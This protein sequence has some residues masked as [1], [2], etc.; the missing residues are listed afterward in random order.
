M[1]PSSLLPA[2]AGPGPGYVESWARSAGLLPL[3][4]VDEAGRGCLAG[5]VV[6]AA[7][8]IPD[9]LQIPGLND[10]KLLRAA[11]RERLEVEIRAG[12]RAI[13][14]GWAGPEVIDRINILQATFGAMRAAVEEAAGAHGGPIGIIIVDGTQVIPRLALPQK[15]WTHGDRLCLACSA[16]SI[17]AKVYR[18]RLMDRMDATYPGYG[19]A[20]H[21]GYGTPEHLDAIRR[22]GPCPIHRM[23][24]A[25][26]KDARRLASDV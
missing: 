1:K 4:G 26:L 12:C 5:P 9:S 2:D 13:G 20:K 17:V 10:S 19:F 8:L 21:K 23:T 11:E 18:D 16:A 7:L 24:F 25:P 3:L 14:V 15:A 22:L 6:A